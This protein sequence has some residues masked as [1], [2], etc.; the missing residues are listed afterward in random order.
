MSDDS[1]HPSAWG[2][3][4]FRR[5]NPESWARSDS[6]HYFQLGLIVF[7]AVAIVYPWYSYKVHTYMLGRD[8]QA[9]A[10]AMEQEATKALEQANAEAARQRAASAAADL[11]RRVSQVRI[12]GI[13]GQ[14]PPVVLV[15]LGRATLEEAEDVVCRQAAAWLRAPTSGRVLRVQRFRGS[16]PALE[17]GE[18]VCR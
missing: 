13:S 18:L 7:V 10:E 9:A 11:Q 16:Q 4:R 6:K 15:D 8:M 12:K 14:S 3:V 1:D 2:N 17:A 5:P